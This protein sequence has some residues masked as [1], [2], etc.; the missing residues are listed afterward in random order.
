MAEKQS[1]Q[2]SR[3]KKINC[4]SCKSNLSIRA[5]GYI[6]TLVC[7]YCGTSYFVN[8]KG[9][10]KRQSG[11]NKQQQYT[12]RT[13]V[14][15]PLIPLG[16][17]GKL[18]GATWEV[19]GFLKRREIKYEFAWEEYLLFNPYKGYRWLTHLD[20]H[21]N[22]ICVLNSIPQKIYD[23]SV[24]CL[25]QRYPYYHEY[26]AENIY[27]AGEFY[28]Q[29]RVGR[30][31]KLTEYVKVPN[32]VS[33]EVLYNQLNQD[34]Y[35]NKPSK[36]GYESDPQ[37]VVAGTKI[38]ASD[39]SPLTGYI[40]ENI[41]SSPE[42]APTLPPTPRHEIRNQLEKPH[43][44]EQAL[45]QM[46]PK[47]IQQY[48]AK[49]LQTT[50]RQSASHKAL[51]EIWSIAEYI[52][53]EDI[54][55]AFGI[56][57]SLPKRKVVSI[58]QPSR[59]RS[60]LKPT[61]VVALAFLVLLSVSGFINNLFFKPRLINSVQVVLNQ[62]Q[63][64]LGNQNTKLLETKSYGFGSYQKWEYVSYPFHIDSR[65]GIVKFNGRASVNN[66][67]LEYDMSLIN[68]ETGDVY[69]LSD[70][71]EYYHGYDDGYWS[72]GSQ[73]SRKTLGRIPNGTYHIKMDIYTNRDQM[74]F[75]YSL[76]EGH[77][78][79]GNFWL[80]ALLGLLPFGCVI[81]VKLMHEAGREE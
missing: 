49:P 17:R 3:I 72:E 69:Y 39:Y 54:K 50:N 6:N 65:R 76:R 15:T 29:A 9:E 79:W 63:P 68:D 10:I 66:N 23:M 33:C 45:D 27:V 53:P 7:A 64:E 32:I 59:V 14:I 20:G 18:K 58:N 81:A 37:D 62:R 31:S 1:K 43:R 52:Q 28:W 11:S 5:I 2:K 60:Y 71:I 4:L 16:T 21:W 22:Y 61:S 73:Y 36:Q 74:T 56:T 8:A 44:T 77:F 41:W 70:S 38:Y 48:E 34:T 80:A 24:K 12:H 19:I 35:Y 78:P 42:S 67:W 30:V 26:L 13:D 25:G 40:E 57:G 75:G 55:E 47:T 46:L 51:E